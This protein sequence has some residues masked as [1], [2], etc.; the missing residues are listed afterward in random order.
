[1]QNTV[2][3]L[4]WNKDENHYQ[5]CI[6]DPKS[7]QGQHRTTI[8]LNI[9]SSRFV[10]FVIDRLQKLVGKAAAPKIVDLTV[11]KDMVNELMRGC[12]LQKV[13]KFEQDEPT[14]FV[15]VQDSENAKGWLFRPYSARTIETDVHLYFGDYSDLIQAIIRDDGGVNVKLS[16]SDVVWEVHKENAASSDTFRAEDTGCEDP[17][18]VLSFCLDFCLIEV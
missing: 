2:T 7:W 8:Q 17:H 11:E 13:V 12:E 5:E 16:Y 1:M 14:H 15:R 10:E 9:T 4:E 3:P 18:K 6:K